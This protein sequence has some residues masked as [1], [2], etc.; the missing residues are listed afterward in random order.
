MYIPTISLSLIITSYLVIELRNLRYSAYAYMLQA[1]LMCSL[2]VAF[3]NQNPGLYY[4]AITAFITKVVVIPY[5]LLR[6]I[7]RT[8]NR[9]FPPLI[10]YL[11]SILLISVIVIIFYR[12]THQYGEFIAPTP[13]ASE[14]PFRTNLAVSLTI[15]VMGLYCILVRRDAIKTVHGLLILENGVHLSLVSLSPLLKETAII[16]I[17]TD[18]VIAVYLLLYV[19]FGVYQKFGS[20]DTFQLKGLRW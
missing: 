12:L 13:A 14:E 20:T 8:T 17:V 15:F 1:V 4:W 11:G 9:E 10:G 7:R 16:G 18:V 3:A 2:F 19:I 6:Y 5:L